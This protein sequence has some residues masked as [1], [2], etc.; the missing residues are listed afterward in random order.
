MEGCNFEFP[1][2]I[3]SLLQLSYY[4]VYASYNMTNVACR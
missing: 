4:L 1:S 2:V 3:K